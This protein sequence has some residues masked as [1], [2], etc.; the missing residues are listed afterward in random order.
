VK[1][2]S[3]VYL[4]MQQV[5]KETPRPKSCIECIKLNS[6]ENNLEHRDPV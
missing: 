1:F 4:T 2:F 5:I 3:P 6:T